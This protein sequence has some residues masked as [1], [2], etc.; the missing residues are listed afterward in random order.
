MTT[1][2]H[3]DNAEKYEDDLKRTAGDAL[4]AISKMPKPVILF[5]GPISTGGFGSVANNIE[6]LLSFISESSKREISVFNQI[7]YERRL[8]CILKDHKDYDYPLLNYFYKPILES[9]K[10]NGLVF[11]PLWQSSVGSTWEHNFATSIGIPI[12]YSEHMLVEEVEK[13]YSDLKNK[14]KPF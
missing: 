2:S 9:R 10:I 11:L 4:F 6:C 14:I 1:I 5:S 12:F 3:R 7:V 8:D 13:F